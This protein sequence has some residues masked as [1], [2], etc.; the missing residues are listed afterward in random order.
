M[1][2]LHTATPTIMFL[3]ICAHSCL[4]WWDYNRLWVQEHI[5]LCWKFSY[6]SYTEESSVKWWKL[7]SHT[8]VRFEG[9]NMLS[10]L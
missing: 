10:V 8:E 1:S 2:S 4:K 3:L 9:A 6:V 7:D 5:S